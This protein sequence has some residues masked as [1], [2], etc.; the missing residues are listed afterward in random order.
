M[1][2]HGLLVLYFLEGFGFE[3]GFVFEDLFEGE[4]L[5]C[6]DVDDV[7]VSTNCRNRTASHSSNAIVVQNIPSLPFGVY[8]AFGGSTVWNSTES[9]GT[10]FD[11]GG[12]FIG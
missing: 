12:I 11:L 5:G 10:Y 6:F 3:G 4:V 9:C 2:V 8:G 7:A 1:E